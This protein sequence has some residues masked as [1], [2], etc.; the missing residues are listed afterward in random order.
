MRGI[1]VFF[2]TVL[3]YSWA[4]WTP[5]PAFPPPAPFFLLWHRRTTPVR[6]KMANLTCPPQASGTSPRSRE[7]REARLS[8]NLAAAAPTGVGTASEH[9]SRVE[10]R[11]Q[12]RSHTRGTLAAGRRAIR[13]SKTIHAVPPTARL[14][15]MTSWHRETQARIA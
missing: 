8:S 14:R 12:T 11:Q 1:V 4:L 15:I 9:Q 13:L 10:R 3:A 6:G 7:A 5:Q 2:A